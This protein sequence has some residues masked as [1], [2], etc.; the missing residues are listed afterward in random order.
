MQNLNYKFKFP[1]TAYVKENGFLGIVGWNSEADDLLISSKSTPVGDFANYFKTLLYK[2]YSEKA[3]NKMKAYIKENNVSF[4]FECCDMEN[5]PH[6]IEYPESKVVLLDVIKNQIEF[7]KLPYD[8]LTELANNM[9]FVLKEKAYVLNTWEDFYDWYNE[10]IDEDYK[11]RDQF[12][13]GFVIED[14]NGY[15]TKLKLHYYNFWKKLR[16]VAESVYKFGNY[17]WT[18][19]LLEPI[20]NEFFGWIKNYYASND[21]ETAVTDICTLRKM[22]MGERK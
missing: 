17:K 22:F 7:E 5:D 1:V 13:E 16:R 12:I 9:G 15:M 21:K 6:I 18:G 19:S 2:I 14:S 20:E 11:Y 10:V 3:I 8:E 4:V